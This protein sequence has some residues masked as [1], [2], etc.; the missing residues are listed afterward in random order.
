ME[1]KKILVLGADGFIGSSLVWRLLKHTNYDIV[2]IDIDNWRLSNVLGNER[3]SFHKFDAL[4]N[5][6]CIENA[7]RD[8]DVVLPLIAIATPATY[9]ENPLLIYNLDFELNADIIKMCVKHKKRVVFP[10]T[11]E[12]YGMCDDASFDEMQSNLVLGSIKNER[13]IYSCSKQMLERLIWAYGKHEGLQFTIFRPFN[14]IGAKL[15]DVTS[16]SKGGSRVITQFIYNILNKKPLKIVD[17]GM[18]RRSFTFIDDG[19]D[20]ILKILQNKDDVASSEIFNIGNPDNEFSIREVAEEL[21]NAVRQYPQFAE[22]AESAVLEDV[23]GTSY[24][25]DGYQDISRRTP[26]IERAKKLLGW[27]PKTNFKDALKLILDY[28]LLQKDY[29]VGV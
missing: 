6:D 20:C 19:V 22:L 10:S 16:S 15:D 8:C 17:G 29:E 2:G 11:S 14:F 26:N 27:S 5:K 24:Y 4:K 9:I 7:I 23:G 18:Q 21:I 13:W 12:V 3:F 28:H 25:G 1:N